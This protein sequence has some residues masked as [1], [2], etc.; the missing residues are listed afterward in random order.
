[1]SSTAAIMPAA[2]TAVG[3]GPDS[4]A[5]AS[6][7]AVAG[8][9][10]YSRWPDPTPRVRLCVA[11]ASAMTARLADRTLVDGR[12]LAVSARPA[13]SLPGDGCDAIYLARIV[14]SELERIARAASGRG[15]VTMTDSDPA[16]LS[17]L[18]FCFRMVTAGLTFDLN[19]DA[20]SRSGVRIDPRVLSLGRREGGRP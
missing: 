17:G 3:D 1:M 10:A 12:S 11:G 20:V 16:C 13:G 14:P 7:D 9:L 8:I 5:I 2:Q 19:I 18:M 15:I 4:V 6:A